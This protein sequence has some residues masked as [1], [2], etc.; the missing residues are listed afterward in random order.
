MNEENVE[1]QIVLKNHFGEFLG[2]KSILTEEQYLNLLKMSK[3]FYA[4][5]GFELTCDDGSF[6]VFPPEI[7]R[8]SMLQV[9]KIKKEENV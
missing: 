9:K 8:Q 5:G 7:V 3:G 2:K 4:G 1:V 6:V